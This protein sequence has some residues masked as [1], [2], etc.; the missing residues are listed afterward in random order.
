ML[1]RFVA[2]AKFGVDQTMCTGCRCKNMVFIRMFV[3]CLS[4]TL[5][6]GG[7]LFVRGHTLNKYCVTVYGSILMCFHLLQ[8]G[9]P[10]Q[11]D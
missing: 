3:F 10:S 2:R 9:L 11:M 7:A 5:G 4:V 6:S 1:S 8:N